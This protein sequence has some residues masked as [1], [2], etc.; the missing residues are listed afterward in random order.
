M[1]IV[2]VINF[3][4][5][6]HLVKKIDKPFLGKRTQFAVVVLLKICR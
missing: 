4:D 1:F 5:T 3:V 2:L 6:I